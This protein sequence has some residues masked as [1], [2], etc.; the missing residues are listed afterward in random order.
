MK[1]FQ[2]SDQMEFT[3]SDLFNIEFNF[4]IFKQKIKNNFKNQKY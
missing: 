3:F 1:H 2:P 4:E